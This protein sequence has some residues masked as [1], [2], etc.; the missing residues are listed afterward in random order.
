MCGYTAKRRYLPHMSAKLVRHW[1]RHI[2]RTTG[3]WEQSGSTSCS[4]VGGG[5]KEPESARLAVLLAE[6]AR[7]EY[8]KTEKFGK[9]CVFG[10]VPDVLAGGR[11]HPD[12]FCAPRIVAP[13]SARARVREGF[14]EKNEDHWRAPL[15]EIKSKVIMVK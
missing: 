2:S 1:S 5:S 15:I 9:N 10:G 8:P 13:G 6:N 11:Q 12:L 4:P 14:P 3:S 7:S